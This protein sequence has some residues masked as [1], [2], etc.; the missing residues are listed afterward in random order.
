MKKTDLYFLLL[1]AVIFTPFFVCD[2][3]YAW[4]KDFNAAHSYIMAFMKFG[5]LATIGEMIGLRIK[6][7]VYSEK[8][9][10]I[11]PRMVVWGLLG[12][13]IASSMRVF[14]IGVP[15]LLESYGVDGVVEAMKGPST[16]LKLL[17]AFGISVMM[18]TAFAPIFMT[19][20]KVTDTHILKCDGG[21]KTF[22]TPIPFGE[23]LSSL[24]WK[25]QW[26][27]VFKKTIPFFWI[28]AHTLTFMLPAELQVL[29]AA[30]LGVALGVLLS[31]AAVKSRK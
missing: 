6:N 10:G 12:I 22:I 30:L 21:L 9:F 3:V 26:S 8:G 1:L 5:I 7:G 27:F 24:N 17:G 29:F 23:T 31:V 13:W 11:F 18:N 2:A 20:H 19:V 28:P 4:Y 14:S 16:S 25:I 15:Y